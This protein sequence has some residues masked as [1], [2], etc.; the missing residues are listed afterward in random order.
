MDPQSQ[1]ERALFSAA[2][3]LA[4][5]ALAVGLLS[6]RPARLRLSRAP[7]RPS[8]V[9][10]VSGE[11]ATPPARTA[12]AGQPSASASATPAP[13]ARADTLRIADV[14]AP[15]SPPQ[16]SAASPAASAWGASLTTTL[17]SVR[18]DADLAG[19]SVSLDYSPP[20]TTQRATAPAAA[21]GSAASAGR[22][23]P[24]AAL[25]ATTNAAAAPAAPA[26][27]QP[28]SGPIGS[29]AMSWDPAVESKV[30]T[31]VDQAR[32]VKS[33]PRDGP[34]DLSN[35][36]DVRQAVLD[37][38]AADARVDAGVRQALGNLDPSADIETKRQAVADVLA[39][40]GQPV[41]EISITNALAR[42][43]SPPSGSPEAPE[44]PSPQAID[45]AVNNFAAAYGGA[46]NAPSGAS[47]DEGQGETGPAYAP[48]E[49]PPRGAAEAYKAH[50][51]AFAA[52][53]KNFGVAPW[54]ILAIAQQET[55]FGRNMGHV[56]LPKG[57]SQR[58][59]DL[60]AAVKL[61]AAARLPA[62]WQNLRGS[63]T[64]ALGPFQFEPA[65]QLSAGRGDPFD[66]NSQIS[67]SV[68]NLLVLNGY[69]PD[70]PTAQRRAFG[71]YYGDGN[72]NGKY[73]LSVAAH[74]AAIKPL[75][76]EQAGNTAGD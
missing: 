42:G 10:S 57:L 51:S 56:P 33:S 66:W 2:L 7:A 61:D 60:A 65:T 58:R 63:E 22:A 16:A 21:T 40:Q 54:D 45:D 76:E 24:G 17:P 59:A 67:Y 14:P 30:S 74:A 18:L 44:Q 35:P 53:L 70:D 47:S 43:V 3:V 71:R 27:R 9:R 41:D 52:A 5:A 23:T 73:A 69:K 34:I 6:R 36:A 55:S 39:A 72:P 68:P 25:A 15:G 13:R 29:G 62:P 64:G 1:N 38:F 20:M 12:V 32:K 37:Q 49:P 19:Q 75:V 50:A 8:A 46:A 48:A 31:L 26:G 11:E 4:G 28:P